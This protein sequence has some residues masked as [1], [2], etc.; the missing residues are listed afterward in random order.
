M[1]CPQWDLSVVRRT[2]TKTWR[3]NWQSSI[4]QRTQFSTLQALIQTLAFSRLYWMNKTPLSLMSLT[5][6]ALS[7]E[8]GSARLKDTDTS[9]WTW[10]SSKRCCKKPNI[11]EWEWLWQTEFFP[12]MAIW[13]HLIK[14]SISRRSTTP[15]HSW[16]S[17][18]QL[19]RLE[20]QEEEHQK[21]L[22]LR[23]RLILLVRLSAKLLEEVLED[24]PLVR[25]KLL[26]FWDKKL[27]LIFFQTLFPHQLLEH[28]LKRS[29][30]LKIVQKSSDN[31]LETRLSSEK[32]LKLLVLPFWVM[33][34]FQSFL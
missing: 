2:F 8:S 17:A 31:S 23:D 3:L 19:V 20:K 14:L 28:R 11:A 30:F 12:W 6:L 13:L 34:A 21:Y 32:A 15:L 4:K 33:T 1:A 25:K 9:I 29:N 5:M 16:M 24:L 27:V 22:D 10:L 18:M 26:K 7:M